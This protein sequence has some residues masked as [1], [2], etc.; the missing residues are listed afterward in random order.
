MASWSVVIGGLRVTRPEVTMLEMASLMNETT[1]RDLIDRYAGGHSGPI[2]KLADWF[3][4]VCG[5]GRAGT[6]IARRELERRLAGD[7][8]ESKM[9]RLFLD[10]IDGSSIPRPVLQWVP[11][12]NDHVR[13]DG[14]YL[15]AMVLVELDGKKWHGTHQRTIADQERDHISTT[16][17]YRTIRFTWSQI[18]F[19][20]K[21]VK[22]ILTG[23]LAVERAG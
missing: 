16:F 7:V 12:W 6:R 15:D 21:Y 13:V 2:E 8:A 18:R 11:P 1:Y 20:P 5:P 14:A 23:A 22:R 3:P 9:E 19:D 10:I 4:T 17:G